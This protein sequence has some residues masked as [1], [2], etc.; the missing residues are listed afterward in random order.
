MLIYTIF[1]NNGTVW[2]PIQLFA[3][4]GL[5]QQTYVDNTVL[6]G[7]MPILCDGIEPLWKCRVAL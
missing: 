1:R 2:L 7:T 6:A 3:Y 4:S 5:G